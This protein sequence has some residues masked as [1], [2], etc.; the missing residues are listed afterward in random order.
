M[1]WTKT[2]RPNALP[3]CSPIATIEALNAADRSGAPARS[4]RVNVEFVEATRKKLRSALRYQL[5][6][7]GTDQWLEELAAEEPDAAVLLEDREP[8]EGRD[9][10]PIWCRPYWR[11]FRDLLSERQYLSQMHFM[12]TAS[13]APPLPVVSSIP[14]PLRWT[15]LR[16]YAR[17]QPL[18]ED[19]FPL[20]AH[21]M[22]ELDAE[23]L[24]V[25]AEQREGQTVSMDKTTTMADE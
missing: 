8:A 6:R 23:F 14:L 7:Q 15:V 21:F 24:K 5:T 20:F 10:I 17:S 2:T 3:S 4:R 18:F 19:D 16:D 9:E 22:G 13:G 11:A 1:A 12:P 25:L